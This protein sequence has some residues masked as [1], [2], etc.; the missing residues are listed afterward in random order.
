MTDT[1]AGTGL[2]MG[3]RTRIEPAEEGKEPATVAAARD[4]PSSFPQAPPLSAALAAATALALAH[5][6]PCA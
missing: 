2:E 1:L 4:P 5:R 6:R 3:I